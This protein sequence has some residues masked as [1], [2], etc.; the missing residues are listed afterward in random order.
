MSVTY[1][2][3]NSLNGDRRYDA[4]QMSSIFDGIIRDGVLQHVGAAMMVNA[5]GD[6][7]ISVGAGRAWFNHTWTLN[8]AP[9]P[10]QIPASEVILNRIDAV[11]IEIDARESSRAN[12][13]KIIKGTPSSNPV[14]PEMVKTG[15]QWQYP[16]AYIRVNA[17]ITSISQANITNCVGTS[18]CPFVTAPL[19]K[20]SIDALVA[21]WGNQWSNW[22]VAQTLEIQNSYLSWEEQ[23]GSW[24]EEKTSDIDAITG[25]LEQQMMAWF[26]NF[27]NSNTS[28]MTNWRE[29]SRELFDAWFAQL[30]DALSGDV[31]ANL[32]NQ[33]LDFQNRIQ[34]L[35]KFS[36][37]LSTEYTVYHKLYDSEDDVIVDDS[38]D[39]IGARVI[40]VIK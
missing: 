35:E 5:S 19:E 22:F 34:I 39:F 33:I 29:E 16:L 28:E 12:A 21:Q 30:Q 37:D 11:I 32:E 15:D 17:G 27:V 20:M 6:M 31:A 18:E 4:T 38:G 40:F 2:F 36:G 8:D 3:Y 9:L 1:G 7:T 10:L 25:S 13:I 14:K 26:N 23:W 24:F